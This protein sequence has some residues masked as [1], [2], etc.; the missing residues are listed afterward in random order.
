M[1]YIG[2]GT[3][4]GTFVFNP[5]RSNMHI[6]ASLTPLK[7]VQSMQDLFMKPLEICI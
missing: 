7:V 1:F 4:I 3:S 5:K 2:T 6:L